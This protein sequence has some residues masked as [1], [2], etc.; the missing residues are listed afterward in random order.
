MD[1]DSNDKKNIKSSDLV[2]NQENISQVPIPKSAMSLQSDEHASDLKSRFQWSQNDKKVG[3]VK[4]R[5]N[6]TDNR[7][8]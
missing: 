2:F 6:R 3:S 8:Q 5:Y 1:F 7:V 4:S